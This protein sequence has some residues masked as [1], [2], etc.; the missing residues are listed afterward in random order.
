MGGRI[1]SLVVLKGNNE[2]VAK[3]TAMQSAAMK[4]SYVCREEV[5]A[6]ETEHE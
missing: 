5:P 1:A 4:P 3:D 6:S 2:E